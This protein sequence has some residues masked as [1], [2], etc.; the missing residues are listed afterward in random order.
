MRSNKVIAYI[1]GFN[2]YHG[3]R[4]KDWRCYYWL[5]LHKLCLHLLK[6][7][8]HLV[9]VKYFTSRIK[10]PN[11]KKKRQSTYIE[12]LNTI[13]GIKLYYGKYQLT[14]TKCKNCDSEF[15]IPD[16]KMTDVQIGAEMVSDA[17]N[18]N[19]DTA[20]L[21]SGD[22]DLV[23]AIEVIRANCPTKRI[24]VVFPPKR[25]ADELRNVANGVMHITESI[26]KNSVL[27]LEITKAGGY[28]LKC[29]SKWNSSK[30]KEVRE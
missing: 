5:N 26:L 20:L 15:E 14:S 30:R 27:P 25:S 1:D 9:I 18:N 7:G 29:P 12:A 19:Y 6:T 3:L 23:P 11:D 2:L 4:D 10:A 24:I 16:E 8:Q 21:I 17:Y 28:V 22:I 13:G